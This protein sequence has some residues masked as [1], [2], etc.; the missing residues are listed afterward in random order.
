[1]YVN[2]VKKKEEDMQKFQLRCKKKAC[3]RLDKLGMAW[4][5]VKLFLSL[6]TFGSFIKGKKIGLI[7]GFVNN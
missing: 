6:C 3:K 2:Q 1:M 5:T 7:A 4:V